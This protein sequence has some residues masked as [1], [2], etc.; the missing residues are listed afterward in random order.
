VERIGL[1]AR[2]AAIRSTDEMILAFWALLIPGQIATPSRDFSKARQEAA[3]LATVQIV[4]R[5]RDV[6]GS[7]VIVGKKGP[8]VYILTAHHIASKS[9]DLEVRTFS[10]A[11]YPNPQ[12]VY[13][14]AVV[15]AETSD[16][17]DLALIRL[18]TN[19]PMPGSLSLCP[20]R[21]VPR[22]KG[23]QALTVGCSEGKAP[24]CLVDS[25]AG[26]KLVRRE[27]ADKALPFWE[28]DRRHRQGRS[29][30]PIV[31]K[32]GYLLGVCS[33]TNRDKTYFCHTEE[34]RAFLKENG[35]DSLL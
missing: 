15:L 21:L 33:G 17:R 8:F 9:K 27:D 35:L 11:S 25:V 3:L 1:L 16:F 22:E 12:R 6:D 7:G 29:G 26:M 28:V 18:T 19:D 2:H 24:T 13:R 31:D 20:G 5:S 4:N 14:S 32:A 23:F 10:L 34:I 30:G